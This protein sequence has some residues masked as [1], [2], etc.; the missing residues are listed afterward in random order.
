M[1]EATDGFKIESARSLTPDSLIVRSDN[2]VTSSDERSEMNDTKTSSLR[3][4]I[5]KFSRNSSPISLESNAKPKRKS[6]SWKRKTKIFDSSSESIDNKKSLLSNEPSLDDINL[7]ATAQAKEEFDKLHNEE[8]IENEFKFLSDKMDLGDDYTR[9]IENGTNSSM[10]DDSSFNFI[11]RLKSVDSFNM[12]TGIKTDNNEHV[13]PITPIDDESN[14]FTQKNQP[15]KSSLNTIL[16]PEIL[17]DFKYLEIEQTRENNHGNLH[18]TNPETSN[19]LHSVRNINQNPVNKTELMVTEHGN[20]LQPTIKKST[21]AETASTKLTCIDDRALLAKDSKVLEDFSEAFHLLNNE[22]T[23]KNLHR[24]PLCDITTKLVNDTK[25]KNKEHKKL[26]KKVEYLET[27]TSE[28]KKA[29]KTIKKDYDELT[30]EFELVSNENRDLYS[31]VKK[32]KK[33]FESTTKEKL[34]L[35]DD[36]KS[37]RQ[38]LEELGSYNENFNGTDS[39]K[40]DLAF[41]TNCLEAIVESQLQLM[42][43]NKRLKDSNAQLRKEYHK[44]TLSLKN[45]RNNEWQFNENFET[46]EYINPDPKKLAQY[47]EDVVLSDYKDT[48]NYL[49]QTNK[50]LQDA[51]HNERL[52]VLDHRKEIQRLKYSVQLIDCY[53]SES[54]QF[55]SQLMCAF[56]DCVSEDTICDYDLYLKSL[57]SMHSLADI[58]SANKL[59]IEA[60]LNTIEKQVSKFY[61]EIASP[62]FL[63]QVV[64]SYASAVKTSS[65]LNEEVNELKR[66]LEEEHERN[67]FLS[68]SLNKAKR[69]ITESHIH[70]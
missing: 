1:L 16:N 48:I 61:Q 37:I 12:N 32:L 56:R 50:K 2:E 19:L 29:V 22:R 47:G 23:T 13:S 64:A 65:F 8:A 31:S 38:K 17:Q 46:T 28:K 44:L 14:D 26:L 59:T 42:E 18:I 21:T 60:K 33:E 67:Q 57:N 36:I 20:Q 63:D 4:F 70:S 52:K 34:S 53:R 10:L 30:K 6:W 51:Y 7:V 66:S 68:H 54:L 9:D 45:S 15:T 27:Y 41:I 5:N 25:A 11:G 40:N 39:R 24:Y 49:K 62:K 58:I 43:Y 3:K 35:K 55:M 69:L